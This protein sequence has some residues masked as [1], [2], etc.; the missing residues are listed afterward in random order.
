MQDKRRFLEIFSVVHLLLLGAA[1]HNHRY[2][3]SIL[4]NL[5]ASQAAH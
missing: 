4:F 1:F 3:S 2:L 5:K